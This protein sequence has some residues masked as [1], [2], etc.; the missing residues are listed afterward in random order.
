MWV[1]RSRSQICR[2]KRVKDYSNYFLVDKPN[3]YGSLLQGYTFIFGVDDPSKEYKQPD[4]FDSYEVALLA[5][6]DLNNTKKVGRIAL[7]LRE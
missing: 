6:K 7:D 1:L 3:N 2:R 5:Y 4:Q